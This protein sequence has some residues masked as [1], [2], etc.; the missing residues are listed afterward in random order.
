L[1]GSNRSDIL[2]SGQEVFLLVFGTAA[3]RACEE[4]PFAAED[5][6]TITTARAAE[7]TASAV[8]IHNERV[9]TDQEQL[10]DS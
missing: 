2:Y 4:E 9:T 1:I 6:H 3:T 7:F 10:C 5:I 8:R